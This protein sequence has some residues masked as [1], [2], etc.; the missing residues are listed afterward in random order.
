MKNMATEVKER[1]EKM[2]AARDA[3][4]QSIDEEMQK[5]SAENAECSARMEAATESSDL[6]A[7]RT[8]KAWAAKL[9]D[10][11]DM[12]AA[13][14]NQIAALKLVTEEESDRTI[15]QLLDYEKDLKE[16]YRTA[17]RDVMKNMIV[18]SDQYRKKVAEAEG[19]IRSW[20][21]N[22]HANYRAECTRFA[23]GTNRAKTPQPVRM[24]AYVGGELLGR[25][26]DFISRVKGLVDL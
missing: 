22:I 4:L 26:D 3:Q 2:I 7:Y 9:Q 14:R 1:I 20:T 21:S 11:F 6:E 19:V 16:E 12:Y 10:A 25:V 18:I 24:A 5:I 8:A 15:D 17:I 23:D 13:R